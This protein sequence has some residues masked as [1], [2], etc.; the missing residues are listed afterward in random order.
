MKSSAHE[1]PDD[2]KTLQAM[3]LS[4]RQLN[5]TQEQQLSEKDQLIAKLQQQLVQFWEDVRLLRQQKFGK[6]SEQNPLQAD[7]FNE[8]EATVD[9]APEPEEKQT[10]TYE[11]NSIA[12]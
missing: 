6:S 11:R 4:E 12:T 1:L 5:A 8:A 2:I 9:E 3:L 7:L 10:I